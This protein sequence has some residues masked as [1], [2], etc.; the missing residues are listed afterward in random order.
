MH[1][2]PTISDS[3]REQADAWDG[4]EGELWARRA[5]SYDAS[6]RAY[7]PQLMAA[8]AISPTD[9]VLDIGCG[10]GQT[11]LDAA[12]AASM[13]G[14]VGIDLSSA[15]LDVGR[16]RA[17]A[18]GLTNAAFIHGDAQ[19]YPFDAKA[20]DVAIS[21]TGVMFFGD[22]DQAFSNIAR[23]LRPGGRIALMAWQGPEPNEWLRAVRSAFAV[24]RDLPSPPVGGQGPLA[25]ASPDE[26]TAMLQR[27][28]FSDV[29][30][31][32]V[33]EP[34]YFG[35]TVDE[36]REGMVKQF[37]WMLDELSPSDRERA[38]AALTHTL[39]THLTPE[40]VAFASAAWLIRAWQ[41]PAA[42]AAPFAVTHLPSR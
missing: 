37:G 34:M 11:T 13:G 27:C 3:N 8:A 26:T 24:G 16:R 42:E 28:G 22:R 17:E 5:D 12:R 33:E 4:P 31:A 40:G 1:D 23:A 25:L 41:V 15:M 14:A 35:R 21:R 39:E 7:H 18:A 20:F 38:L 10:S 9:Q 32:G 30:I 2:T 29:H 36:T 19:V 6:V